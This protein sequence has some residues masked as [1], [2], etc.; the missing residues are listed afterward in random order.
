DGDIFQ[1]HSTCNYILTS[2]CQSTYNDFNIQIRRQEAGGSSTIQSIILNLQAILPVSRGGVLI[3]KTSTYIKIKA[4]LGLVAFWNEEDSFLVELDQ[5]FKNQ[6]CGLCGDFNG[7]QLHD[8]FYSHGTLRDFADFWKM[9]GP[10]EACSDYTVE[11]TKSCDNLILMGPA[12]SSCQNLLDIASFTSACV[13]D[14]CHCGNSEGEKADPHCLCDTVSEFSRQCVHA[15]GKPQNWRTEELCWKSCQY[16]MEYNECGSPCADTCSNPDASLTCDSHCMDGCFCP[17]GMVF[18][19]LNERG[20]V[21]LSECSCSY[22]SKTYGPGE[23]YSSNCKKCVCKSGQ[24]EC[25][26]EDCPGICSVEGGA[27]IKSFDGKFY[28]FHGDCSYVLAKDCSGTQFVIQGELVQCGKTESETC[29]KSVTLGLSGGANVSVIHKKTHTHTTL[30]S[31]FRFFNVEKKQK[32]SLH[33][34]KNI[35]IEN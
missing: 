32:L 26:E 18:D 14:L 10:T 5:K 23:S 3:E 22:N 8:E 7:V 2:S 33:S 11:P 35:F 28:T 20:C 25:Q 29:L 9:N 21:P 17:A 12:F 15:G 30:Y 19:D 24:W 1:L 16:Q 31:I 13:A 27:H 4:K 34:F 6:T